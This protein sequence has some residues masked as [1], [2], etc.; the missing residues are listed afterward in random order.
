[1]APN[2]STSKQPQAQQD[3]EVVAASVEQELAASG[4][5]LAGTAEEIVHPLKSY[6]ETDE[7]GLVHSECVCVLFVCACVRSCV[8]V[9]VCVRARVCV[10]V[11]AR[12][13]ACVC[14]CV[15]DKGE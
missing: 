11:C 6:D 4:D 10:C 14:V 8:F 9:F 2:S 13:R 12:V 5:L 1:M 7:E 3:E 15:R